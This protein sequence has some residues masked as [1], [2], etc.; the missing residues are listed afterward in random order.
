MTL[1]KM[2][3]DEMAHSQTVCPQR[4][5]KFYNTDPRPTNPMT[6]SAYPWIHPVNPM[7][8]PVNPMNKPVNPTR[9]Y[10]GYRRNKYNYHQHEPC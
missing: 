8:K 9:C 4:R 3:A 2:S 5:K 1:D 10:N 6:G 7:N